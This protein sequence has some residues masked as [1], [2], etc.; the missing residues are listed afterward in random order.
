MTAEATMTAP[1]T[2]TLE[3]DDIQ[4]GA[5]MPRPTPTPART[6]SC[7]SM[8]GARREL[9][10]RLIPYLDS[11]ASFNPHAP[12][13]LG[14]ATRASRRSGCRRTRWPASRPSSSRAW[15]PARPTWG[16]WGRTRLSTGSN[17]SGRRTS[18]SSWSA[19]R[20]PMTTW[21]PRSTMP[22]TPCAICPASCPSGGRTCTCR[23]TCATVRLRRRHQPPGRRGQRHPRHQ[24]ARRAAQGGRVRAGVRGRDLQRGPRPAA[25]GA[26]PQ[27][28]LRVFRKL[29]T[30]TA[31]WRQYLHQNAAD[32][33]RRS[34]WA[35][36]SSGAGR[37]ARHPLTGQGRP[38]AGRRPE[39]Q[40]RLHVRRRPAGAQ[41]PGR[42]PRAADEP[43]R[44]GRHRPA[45]H[46]PHDPARHRL[47]AA[48]APGVLE[49]DGAD[50]GLMF[51]FVG[52]HLDRQFEFVQ[53]EWVNDGKFIGSPADMIRWW[54]RTTVGVHHP[55][56]A[57]PPPPQGAASPSSAARRIL[58]PA[59]PEGAA[60][61]RRARHVTERRLL[62]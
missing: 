50:R 30:R 32:A 35:P 28:H 31:A 8:T 59:R 61:A 46:P 45:A 37:A 2:E 48:A 9:L 39:P 44:C 4:A 58:L 25:G 60:L 27:R 52:A 53:T 42:L 6:R 17:R 3:L 11:A 41:M 33:A 18:I 13:A 24:P 5:L 49:D 34:G 55:P 51:A 56:E 57:D 19:S 54:A 43:P 23:R 10:R 15:P 62:A 14:V 22:A 21:R 12:V 7:A 26:R 47:R 29:H 40:Q 1:A 20:S 36:R 16:T 38:R